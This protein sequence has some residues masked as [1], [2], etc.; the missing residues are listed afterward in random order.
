M[1]IRDSNITVSK[2]D[3]ENLSVL[4][5]GKIPPNPAELI[6]SSRMDLSLIHIYGFTNCKV[7]IDDGWSGTN[8]ARPAF[9]EIMELAEQ[10]KI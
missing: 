4:T 9:R 1:C 6:S 10:G 7:F 5:G 8:F 2:T 3:I